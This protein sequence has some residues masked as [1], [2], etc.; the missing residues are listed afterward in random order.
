MTKKEKKSRN[1]EHVI[2]MNLFS[3]IL[4]KSSEAL[5]THGLKVSPEEIFNLIVSSHSLSITSSFSAFCIN[6]TEGCTK[7]LSRSYRGKWTLFG[8]NGQITLNHLLFTILTKSIGADNWKAIPFDLI[9]PNEEYK[10]YSKKIF[11]TINIEDR[12]LFRH[13]LESIYEQVFTKDSL[14]FI[15]MINLIHGKKYETIENYT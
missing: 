7:F 2:I 3:N 8:T 10:L 14:K 11:E 4:E 6:H 9:S 15:K 1:I 12:E 5:A 13:E